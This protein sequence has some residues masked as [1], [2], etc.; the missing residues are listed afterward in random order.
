MTRP[1]AATAVFVLH[2]LFVV[3]A[4]AGGFGVLVSRWWLVVHLPI[5]AW[6]AYVNLANRPCPLTSLESKLRGEASNTG[7]DDGFI[8]HYIGRHLH[9]SA[10]PQQIEHMVGVFIIGWNALVYA[11][12]WWRAPL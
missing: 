3:L 7:L 6:S 5:V 8:A 1:V 12:V 11:F 9:R 10:T 2:M 4:L